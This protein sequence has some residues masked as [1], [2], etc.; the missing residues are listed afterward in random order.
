MEREKSVL[1][2]STTWAEC[3]ELIKKI[4]NYS[5][6][7]SYDIVA[8]DYGLKNASAKSFKYKVSTAKQFGL[9]STSGG[10]LELTDIAHQYLYPI[11]GYIQTEIK[12]RCFQTPPLY[13]KLIERFNGKTLPNVVQLGNLLLQSF[14]IVKSVKDNAAQC[15]IDNAEQMGVCS[16]GVLN[17]NNATN[18]IETPPVVEAKENAIVEQVGATAAVESTPVEPVIKARNVEKDYIQQNYETENGK[19]AQIIIPKDA[20][21]DDLAAITDLL[22]ILIKRRFKTDIS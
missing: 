16:N 20:T 15:F 14:G 19:L 1:Y 22:T 4:D 18:S 11:N 6:K 10:A 21:A 2:P 13:I 3:E 9:I 12:A 8:Q 17:C 5:G 7:V